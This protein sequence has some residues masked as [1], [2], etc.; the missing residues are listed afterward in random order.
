M[1]ENIGD[2]DSAIAESVRAL[3][4]N[5]NR[6]AAAVAAAVP[7]AVG[8]VPAP[9]PRAPRRLEPTADP[10]TVM[11]NLTAAGIQFAVSK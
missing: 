2:K 3:L 9:V 4:A 10:A 6:T 1:A 11:A 7:D 5:A 8:P